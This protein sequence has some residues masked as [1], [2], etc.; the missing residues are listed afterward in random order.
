MNILENP[1]FQGVSEEEWNE[2]ETGACLRRSAYQ[3][4]EL[5]CQMGD[6]VHEIG[7]VT[8]GSVHIGTVDFWGNKSILSEVHAG[9]VFAETYACCAE[10][11]MVEVTAAEDTRLIWMD[12]SALR[13]ETKRSWQEKIMRN[14]LKISLRKN[15]TLSQRIF[16]TTP[17]T[18]RE[19]VLTYLTAQ[20]VKHD[21]DMIDIPFNRQQMADYLNLDR[22]ALSKE[23]GRM[24]K[25]GILD[26]HKNVFRLLV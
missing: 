7:I 17:K 12:V 19:R 21:S 9:G 8:E 10:P 23:L 20:S 4:N 25:E 24:K 6:V 15:L 1:L 26:F 18:I 13:G 14:M 11:M 2:M 22:S 5:I 3:K 16:C